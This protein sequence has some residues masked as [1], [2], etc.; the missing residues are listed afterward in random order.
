MNSVHVGVIIQTPH[1]VKA[2]P[3]SSL[4]AYLHCMRDRREYHRALRASAGYTEAQRLKRQIKMQEDPAYA[5]QERAYERARSVRRRSEQ[6]DSLNAQARA[7]HAA[8][9]VGDEDYR[10]GKASNALRWVKSNPSKAVA[11]VMRRDAQNLR[12]VPAW[13]DK[14]KIQA[15]YDLA[16]ANR[17]A[18]I[19]C[20]VDHIVPLRSPHVCGLH[21]HQNLQLLTPLS[22][23]TKG[24][25]HWPDQ[26]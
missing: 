26:H 13:A 5:K 16:A 8:R 20:E 12:A 14:A 9:M 6:R 11:N 19:E 1:K 7:R 10:K 4:I 17:A 21:V 22:N 24:N 25:R 18:G 23:R 2:R 15:I 3:E